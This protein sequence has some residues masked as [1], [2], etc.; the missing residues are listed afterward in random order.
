[1]DNNHHSI[2]SSIKFLWYIRLRN[3]FRKRMIFHECGY[4]I[5]MKRQYFSCAELRFPLEMPE[6]GVFAK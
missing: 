5:L 6:Q 3:T 2:K 1:M 4:K